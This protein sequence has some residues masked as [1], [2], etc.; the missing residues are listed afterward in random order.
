MVSMTKE[1]YE[2]VRRM[3]KFFGSM[4]GYIRYLIMSDMQ[5]RIVPRVR[6]IVVREREIEM[7][8]EHRVPE[9]KLLGYGELHAELMREMKEKLKERHIE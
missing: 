4:S 3:G 5:P 7:S 6:R 8:S 9:R 1:M 2:Y